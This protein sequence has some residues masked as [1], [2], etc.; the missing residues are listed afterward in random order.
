MDAANLGRHSGR[1]ALLVFSMAGLII[2]SPFV[3]VGMMV[4]DWL[5]SGDDPI[6]NRWLV[7]RII[8]ETVILGNLAVLILALYTR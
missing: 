7:P 4:R 2:L 8:W 3:A 1:H 5:L 6:E